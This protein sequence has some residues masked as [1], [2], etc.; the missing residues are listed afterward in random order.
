M[1]Y[2]CFYWYNKIILKLNVCDSEGIKDF[3]YGVCV[4]VCFL[5]FFLFHFFFG[6]WLYWWDFCVCYFV[7]PY[8]WLQS[9]LRDRNVVAMWLSTEQQ[10]RCATNEA[11]GGVWGVWGLPDRGRCPTATGWAPH[12]QAACWVCPSQGWDRETQGEM[13]CVCVCVCVHEG[14]RECVCV[15]KKNY[16]YADH[17]LIPHFINNE[18]AFT[19]ILHKGT[20]S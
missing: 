18:A 14:E 4:C 13:V 11:D 5:F 10:Q 8:R 6:C 15:L 16:D 3:K 19:W 20:C 2:F 1:V 17:R 7:P 12:G 9:I